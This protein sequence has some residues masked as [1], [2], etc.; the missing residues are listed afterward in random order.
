[1]LSCRNIA[2]NEQAPVERNKQFGRYVSDLI[3]LSVQGPSAENLPPPF[4]VSVSSRGQCHIYTAQGD[5]PNGLTVSGIPLGV[6][7]AIP[8][9]ISE[10]WTATAIGWF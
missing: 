3:D 2:W 7:H 5:S 1:M 4:K 8:Y 9:C 6:G 10:Y